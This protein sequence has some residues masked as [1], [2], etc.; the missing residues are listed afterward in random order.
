MSHTSHSSPQVPQVLST[1]HTG[2]F[3]ENQSAA[4]SGSL[5]Q[6]SGWSDAGAHAMKPPLA[7]SPTREYPGH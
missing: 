7:C 4:S 3:S 1:M 2:S 6:R 5:V